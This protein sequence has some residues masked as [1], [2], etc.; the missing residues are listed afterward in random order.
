MKYISFIFTC[1][2]WTTS[3]SQLPA[4][5]SQRVP[6]NAIDVVST[7]WKIERLIK[8]R[9]VAVPARHIYDTAI[10][11]KIVIAYTTDRKGKVIIAS[12]AGSKS[13]S[14][15][16]QLIKDAKIKTLMA[17]PVIHTREGIRCY[18]TYA[19][20][21]TPEGKLLLYFQEA[22]MYDIRIY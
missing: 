18:G 6:D 4:N 19:F 3:F 14:S 12:Y 22:S 1:F 10:S 7:P 17:K 13:T 9:S 21:F 20:I 15:D 5:S 8:E 2:I 16:E 11:K